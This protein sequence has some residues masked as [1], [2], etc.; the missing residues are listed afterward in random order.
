MPGVSSRRV[1]DFISTPYLREQ[2]ILH[3]SP[4]GYGQRGYKWA[5]VV[6]AIAKQYGASSILDYGCGQGSLAKALRA[7]PLGSIRVDEYDPAIPGKDQ[8]PVFADMVNVTDVLEHVELDRLPAVLA[9]LRMLARKVLWVVVSTTETAKVLSDGRNAHINIQS[10]EWWAQTMIDSGF[11]I[12]P[13]PI[14]A[15]CKPEKE[16]IAV[17]TP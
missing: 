6:L 4:R 14:E 8:L 5:P 11:A 1:A 12:H 17:L 3:E 7:E 2:Q 9:H 13:A 10:A 16:W 15:R